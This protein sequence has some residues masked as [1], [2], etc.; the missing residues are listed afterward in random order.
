MHTCTPLPTTP[1]G[2]TVEGDWIYKA[3][4]EFYEKCDEPRE[5]CRRVFHEVIEKHMPT[6]KSQEAVTDVDDVSNHLSGCK[7]E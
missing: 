6:P 1:V 7:C 5:E 4:D 3:F 2:G